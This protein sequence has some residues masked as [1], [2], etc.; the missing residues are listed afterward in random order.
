MDLSDNPPVADAEVESDCGAVTTADSSGYFEIEVYAGTR[1]LTAS[2]AGYDHASAVCTVSEGGAT[3]CYVPVVPAAQADPDDPGDP[4][5]GSEDPDVIGGCS[6]A[7]GVGGLAP[8]LL[9][10]WL[11]LIRRRD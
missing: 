9:L 10:G 8:L 7:G 6:T 2:A 11:F 4:F 3:E 1:I 5:T